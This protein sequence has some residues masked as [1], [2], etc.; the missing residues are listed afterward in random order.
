MLGQFCALDKYNIVS[1]ENVGGYKK[2][3]FSPTVKEQGML[4]AM[5]KRAEEQSFEGDGSSPF[6]LIKKTSLIP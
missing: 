3:Y 2:R 5:G 4:L 6:E 1:P